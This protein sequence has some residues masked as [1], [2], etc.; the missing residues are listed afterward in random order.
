MADKTWHPHHTNT[1][2]IFNR[3]PTLPIARKNT[4]PRIAGKGRHHLNFM[5]QRLKLLRKCG[6]FDRVFGIKQLRYEQ[7]PQGRA[8]YFFQTTRFT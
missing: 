6:T 5:A 2:H 3:P 7:D 1:T 8:Q 4:P